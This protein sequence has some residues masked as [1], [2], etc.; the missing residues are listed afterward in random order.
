MINP[1]FALDWTSI[2]RQ[3]DSLR[4]PSDINIVSNF[5][6][7]SSLNTSTV[8]SLKE[9][10][11]EISKQAEVKQSLNMPAGKLGGAFSASRSFKKAENLMNNNETGFATASS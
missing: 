5:G 11:D 8:T 6:C 4:Y 7:S 10:Q 3:G 2:T 9:Y 1:I